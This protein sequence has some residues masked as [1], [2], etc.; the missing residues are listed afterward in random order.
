MALAP[1]VTDKHF[2]HKFSNH[3]PRMYVVIIYTSKYP[4]H[5]GS[6]A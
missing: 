6:C 1:K 2:E 5:S 3:I 4:P